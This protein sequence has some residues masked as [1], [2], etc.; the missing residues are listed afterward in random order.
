MRS[1]E[2]RPMNAIYRN[3]VR[4]NR[5]S[6]PPTCIKEMEVPAAV[7]KIRANVSMDIVPL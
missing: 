1:A 5:E 3:G 7:P 4:E 6:V 2:K